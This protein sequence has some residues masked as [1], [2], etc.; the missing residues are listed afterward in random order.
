[1]FKILTWQQ[2]VEWNEKEQK[3][4]IKKIKIKIK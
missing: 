3:T 2:I 4:L 1:M